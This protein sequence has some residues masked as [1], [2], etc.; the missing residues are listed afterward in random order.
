MVGNIPQ[1]LALIF[2]RPFVDIDVVEVPMTKGLE[3]ALAFGAL[4]KL[5]HSQTIQRCLAVTTACDEYDLR[6]VAGHVSRHGLKP[7]GT[8]DV[9]RTSFFQVPFDF[10]GRVRF[11]GGGPAGEALDHSAERNENGGRERESGAE[12]KSGE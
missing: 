8:C 6:T 9:A 2:V 12:G 7:T 3:H 11:N 5:G 10:P 1:R 4:D